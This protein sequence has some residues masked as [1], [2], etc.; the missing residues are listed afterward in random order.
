VIGSTALAVR[1]AVQGWGIHRT[2]SGWGNV[3]VRYS[4]EQGRYWIALFGEAG[5]RAG[6]ERELARHKELVAARSQF[7]QMIRQ[8][9][10]R[11]IM[12]CDRAT[13]LA[14]SDGRRRKHHR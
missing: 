5:E 14:R 2:K 1:F 4:M 12:L 6:I 3:P 8:Y 11:L 13:V 7:R 10:G 9:P